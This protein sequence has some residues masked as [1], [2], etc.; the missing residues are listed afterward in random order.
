MRSVCVVMSILCTAIAGCGGVAEP[1][2][3]ASPLD[4]PNRASAQSSVICPDICGTGTQCQYP[5]GSCREACN[6]CLCQAAGGKV[7][8]SCD[9]A[10]SGSGSM[11]CPDICGTGTQCQHPDGSCQEAC[12]DCLCQRAGGKVVQRCDAASSSEAGSPPAS[13]PVPPELDEA[14]PNSIACGNTFCGKGE[15][16]CNPSCS[17][18]VPIGHFCTLQVCE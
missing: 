3:E 18:C 13:S 5:D 2:A 7:V 12:N 6:D 11:I 15:Y 8:Q 1:S 4:N 10:G 17:T 16:C 9:A 14:A